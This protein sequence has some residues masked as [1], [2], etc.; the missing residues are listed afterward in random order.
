MRSFQHRW[1]EEET[2]DGKCTYGR[3]WCYLGW[4]LIYCNQVWCQEEYEIE[5]H[6]C[7]YQLHNFRRS[8]RPDV[9]LAIKPICTDGK[10]YFCEQGFKRNAPAKPCAHSVSHFDAF[11]SRCCS[12]SA[13]FKRGA[14]PGMPEPTFLR[15]RCLCTR[16]NL[17]LLLEHI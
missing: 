3:I 14:D 16:A 7:S 1:R 15:Y 4:V 9:V 17:S 2:G 12:L 8:S 11:H 13:G 10:F 5:F 6:T